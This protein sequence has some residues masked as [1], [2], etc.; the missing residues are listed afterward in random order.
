ML[1][2]VQVRMARAALKWS[3]LD[4]AT[5]AGISTGPLTRL[6][7]GEDVQAR[8]LRAIE[9]VFKEAG[10]EFIEEDDGGPGVRLKK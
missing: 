9:N 7:K 10:I 8:T 6:E 1:T 5:K 4:L 2:A 3:N